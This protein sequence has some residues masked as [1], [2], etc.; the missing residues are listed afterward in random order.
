M[1][2]WD[3]LLTDAR[4][5]T[6][7]RDVAPY[8]VIDDGA[9]AIAD[10]TIAWVGEASSLPRDTADET[11]SLA[12]GWVTPALI[13]C[14]T[15]LVFGGD[16]SAEFEQRLSGV[17]YE[18]IARAGGGILSTVHATRNSS[19]DELFESASKRLQML[20][21]DGVATVEIKSGYGLDAD[22]EIRMLEVA[23]RLGESSDL[24]VYTTLLAAH[25]IPPEFSARPDMYVDLICSRLIPEAAERGLADAVDDGRSAMAQVGG[26]SEDEFVEVSGGAEAQ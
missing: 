26:T 14:H 16:R 11:I 18:E 23:R 9:I 17:S 4:I 8:G 13:D 3:R 15:H 19:S 20:Q 10:G 6:M 7:E 1:A 5:A 21:A 22:T 2:H 25:A 12:G 24:S